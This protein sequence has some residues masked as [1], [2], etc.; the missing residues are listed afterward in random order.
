VKE[1]FNVA[2]RNNI[3]T[4]NGD[5]QNDSW[6]IENLASY[7]NNKVTIIDR[8]GRIVYSKIN[9]S[10]DWKAQVNGFDLPKG[11]YYYILTFNNGANEKKGFISII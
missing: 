5:G 1:D 7:P 11:T 4:P 9:Y 3:L 6:I 8:F 10:N 2:S